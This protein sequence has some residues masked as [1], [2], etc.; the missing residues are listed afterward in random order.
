MRLLLI[1]AITLSSLLCLGCNSPATPNSNV[2]VEIGKGIASADVVR[3]K[4]DPVM[5]AAGGTADAVVRLRIQEGY[6]VNA[7]PPTEP[8]LIPT[9][10][11]IDRGQGIAVN[12]IVYPDAIKKSFSFA[13]QPL[14][15]Y[16]GETIVRVSL[17][18]DD[19]LAK[20]ERHLSGKLRIQACDDEVC[21][22]PGTVDVSIPITVN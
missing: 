9:E 3:V 2:T 11:E 4:P 1:L 12:F 10:L 20:G 8:Y 7:N 5:I 18:A 13:K 19:T 22:P 16:E 15:V 21:Y 6:H 14:A 17:K